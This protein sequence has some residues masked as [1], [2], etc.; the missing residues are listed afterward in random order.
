M[1]KLFI[2]FFLSFLL[3]SCSENTEIKELKKEVLEL[4]QIIEK[5]QDYNN[6]ISCSIAIN[7]YLASHNTHF[8]NL[9]TGVEDFFYSKKEN[10]CIALIKFIG[11]YN[12]Y[13]FWK[14]WFDLPSIL[15]EDYNDA[16]KKMS[17][18]KNEHLS[19]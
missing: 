19:Q 10:K 16:I 15:T 2:L 4:K 3:F 18:L 5:Q 14:E 8:N 17:E 6:N 13:K 7:S 9:S 12:I 1:K 11:K